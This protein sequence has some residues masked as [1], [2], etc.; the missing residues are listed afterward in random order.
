MSVRSQELRSLLSRRQIAKCAGAHDAAGARLAYS[1]GF[2][3]IWSSSF[4]I[5]ASNCVPDASILS[6]SDFLSVARSLAFSVPIP[7]IADCDTGYGGP[8]N[9]EYAVR[10]FESAGVAGV[11]IEDQVFPKLNSLT[12]GVHPLVSI[13]EFTDKIKA[14]KHAQRDS[15]F[16]VIA[17]VEALIAGTGLADA[18]RRAHAYHEAGAD[19]ILIHWNGRDIEPIAQ[20][21]S[22]WN[23]P[24]PVILVPTT[25]YGVSANDLELLGASMVIYANHGMRAALRAMEQVF[26]SILRDG[27]TLHIEGSIWPVSRI[28]SELQHHPTDP[29]CENHV[30][31]RLAS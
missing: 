13:Q 3:A 30:E 7:V 21:L 17:R 29:M 4:E 28:I 2:D 23:H 27:T 16:V 14:A 31:S 10:Q 9:V 24:A 25:Y 6:M 22:E 19:A 20:F 15:H 8:G 11:S 12:P 26:Q 1:V 18:I 5:S